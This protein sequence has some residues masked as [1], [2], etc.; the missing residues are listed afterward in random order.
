MKFGITSMDYGSLGTLIASLLVQGFDLIGCN[1]DE[2]G[3]YYFNEDN[4]NAMSCWINRDKYSNP[5]MVEI[6][7]LNE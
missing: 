7:F 5:N 2:I 4:V 3:N 1:Y 6:R